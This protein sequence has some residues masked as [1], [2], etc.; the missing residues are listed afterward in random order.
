M[1]RSVEQGEGSFSYRDVQS[2]DYSDSGYVAWHQAGE[3]QD[4]VLKT[5]VDSAYQTPYISYDSGSSSTVISDTVLECPFVQESPDQEDAQKVGKLDAQRRY[6]KEADVIFL[7]PGTRLALQP[8]DVIT[9]S[10][11]NYGGTYTVLIDSMKINKDCS[12]QFTCSKYTAAFNDWG[13][14]NPNALPIATD[15]VADSWRPTITGAT[16]DINYNRDP[17]APRA[18]T[19]A[20]VAD[21]TV[22]PNE[23]LWASDT[24]TLYVE[25]DGAKIAIGGGGDVLSG[26]VFS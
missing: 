3:G 21:A 2:T 9:I 17:I 24:E 26:Q 16:T 13:D 19:A 25:Q 4:D 15:L 20:G 8:D 1:L 5:L 22:Y 6:N 18:G 11:A 7:A 10:A 12:I 23:L 14:L